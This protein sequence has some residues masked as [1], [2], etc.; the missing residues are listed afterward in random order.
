MQEHCQRGMYKYWLREKE[1]PSALISN[2]ETRTEFEPLH[3]I[4]LAAILCHSLPL[5]HLG[6]FQR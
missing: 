5:S 6:I 2:V 3:E 4:T 1:P